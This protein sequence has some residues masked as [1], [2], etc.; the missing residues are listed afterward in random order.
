M[1]HL[2]VSEKGN[3]SPQIPNGQAD[4]IIA[5]EPSEALRL[6]TV[7]GNSQVK[8]LSNTRPIHPVDVIAGDVKYP[9][10]E[11][12]ISTVKELVAASWFIAATDEAMKMGNPIYGNIIV[13]GALSATDS[14][15]MDRE[16]FISVIEDSFSGDRLKPNIDAYD[17][18]VRLAGS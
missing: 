13:L 15:P 2:R 1:S 8:V 5:L 9:S 16:D 7:Y 11:E 14:L 18:G 4:F 12:I 10:I 6:L 3:W 17:L